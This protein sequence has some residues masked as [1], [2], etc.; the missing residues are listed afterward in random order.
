MKKELKK[1]TKKKQS[2]KKNNKKPDIRV[3]TSEKWDS[4]EAGLE[5][6]EQLSKIKDISFVMLFATAQYKD[7]GGFKK[8]LKG[9]Y[10]KIDDN[11]Q[12]VGGTVIGFTTSKI[13]TVQGVVALAFSYKNMDIAISYSKNTKRHP[14]RSGKKVAK[15]IKSSLENSKYKNKIVFTFTAGSQ[16]LKFPFMRP[17]NIISFNLP[18]K[19]FSS[20][21]NFVRFFFQKGF[22]QEDDVLEK[23]S[24][25][26][27]D[28]DL[29]GLSMGDSQILTSHQFLNKKVLRNSIVCLGISKDLDYDLAFSSGAKQSHIKFKITKLSK[30]KRIIHE[31]NGKPA[32]DELVRLMG[33]KKEMVLDEKRWASI[34]PRFPLGFYKEGKIILR[35]FVMIMGKSLGFMSKIESN[36]AFIVLMSGKNILEAKDELVLSS[37]DLF[38]FV[39]SCGVRAMGLGKSINTEKKYFQ[40]LFKENFLIL[41]TIGE[42]YK[43]K[44]KPL[45]YLNESMVKLSFR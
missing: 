38:T 14:F 27:S 4:K 40:K 26:F 19:F 36:D 22:G 13:S 30:D 8:L 6:S 2:S 20:F 1:D 15:D 29:F 28:C 39:N 34:L 37:Q 17:R 25:E 12:L 43:K 5:I 11:T 9:V 33:W 7:Y 21:L 18:Y 23:F 35:P 31:I 44:N 10:E 45:M 24:D 41:Y 16:V 3:V 32:L 42:A